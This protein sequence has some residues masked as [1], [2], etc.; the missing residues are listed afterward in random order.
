[1]PVRLKLKNLQLQCFLN[2]LFAFLRVS[3]ALLPKMQLQNFGFTVTTKT[4]APIQV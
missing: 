4:V 2:F 1:M 3:F